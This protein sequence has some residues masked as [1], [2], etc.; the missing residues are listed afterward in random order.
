MIPT[1][2]RF[3]WKSG[4]NKHSTD[5]L[6]RFP[7]L[8]ILYPLQYIFSVVDYKVCFLKVMSK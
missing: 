5:K 6:S 4:D 7:L 2:F 3:I 1:K 8:I